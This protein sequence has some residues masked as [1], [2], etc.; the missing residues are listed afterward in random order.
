MKKA[1]DPYGASHKKTA[2]VYTRYDLPPPLNTSARVRGGLSII[3][4]EASL[5]F[6]V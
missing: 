1:S 2:C 4:G 5:S 6:L 3:T